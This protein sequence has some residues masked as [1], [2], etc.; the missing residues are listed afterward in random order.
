MVVSVRVPEEVVKRLKQ[1]GKNPSEIV[2]KALI[3]ASQE[4]RVRRLNRVGRRIKLPPWEE[5]R[6]MIEEGRA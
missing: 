4:E 5:L 3:A 2:K 1:L 6:E